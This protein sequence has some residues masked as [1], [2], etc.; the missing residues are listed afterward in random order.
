MYH[1]LLCHE[2]FICIASHLLYMASCLEKQPLWVS[3]YLIH[4]R[5]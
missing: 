3:L 1:M 4:V 2:P 5:T